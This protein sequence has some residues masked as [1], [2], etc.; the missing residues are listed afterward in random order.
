MD[1]DKEITSLKD[2]VE[3]LLLI[4]KEL[5]I[6]VR[7]LVSIAEKQAQ[8]DQG[9]LSDAEDTSQE[10][11]EVREELEKIKKSIGLVEEKTIEGFR[12]REEGVGSE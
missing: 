10:S 12:V 4:T 6:I 2:M 1:Y 7:G 8:L 11:R 9:L 3:I 5:G